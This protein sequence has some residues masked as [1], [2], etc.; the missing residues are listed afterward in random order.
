MASD[1]HLLVIASHCESEGPLTGLHVVARTFAEALRHQKRGD[2]DVDGN[3][4]RAGILL[5]AD[6]KTTEEAVKLAAVSARDKVLVLVWIGHGRAHGERFFLMPFE[7]R[8]E[9]IEASGI[10]LIPLLDLIRQQE[11]GGLLLTIDACQSGS[12][13]ADA[14]KA[15]VETLGPTAPIVILTATGEAAAYDLSFTKGL[16]ELLR[17]G[18]GNADRELSCAMLRDRLCELARKQTAHLLHYHGAAPPTQLW[19]SHNIAY[20]RRAHSRAPELREQNLMLSQVIA[21]VA[22][23]LMIDSS[24]IA[25]IADAGMGKTTLSAMLVQ[26]PDNLRAM[27]GRQHMLAASY[28][29]SQDTTFFRIVQSLSDQFKLYDSFKDATLPFEQRKDLSDD[30]RLLLEPLRTWVPTLD[31]PSSAVKITVLIDSLDSIGVARPRVIA[32]LESLGSIPGVRVVFTSRSGVEVPDKFEKVELGRLADAE[33]KSYLAGMHVDP[34]VHDALLTR[35]EGNWLC[36]AIFAEEAR[37]RRISDPAQITDLTLEKAFD[38]RLE[39]LEIGVEPAGGPA[40]LLTVLFVTLAAAGTGAAMPV[41]LLRAAC[42]I[43]SGPSTDTEFQAALKKLGGLTSYGYSNETT[44]WGLFH[45]ELVSHVHRAEKFRA[46]VLVAHAAIVDTLQARIPNRKDAPSVEWRYAFD[47][48]LDHWLASGRLVGARQLVGA[49]RRFKSIEAMDPRDN[50]SFWSRVSRLFTENLEPDHPVVLTARSNFAAWVGYAG[51]ARGARDLFGNLLPEHQRALGP[52][53]SD[54]LTT[55]ANLA[56]WTG[57]AGDAA[58]ARDLFAD[59]LPRHTRILGANDPHVLL[60][61]SNLAR[62]TGEAGDIHGAR[63]LLTILLPEYEEVLGADDAAVLMTRHNLAD[64]VGKCGDIE[65]ARDLFAA[66]LPDHERV[67]GAD[68]PEVLTTRG[69]LAQCT[70]EAGDIHAAR[71]LLVAY[72]TDAERALGPDHRNVLN[73]RANLAG[74]MRRSGDAQGAREIFAALLPKY[75]QILGP[76]HPDV[77]M[78]RANHAVCMGEA[79]DA[80]GARALLAA[81]LADRERVIGRDHPDVLTMRCNLAGFTGECGDIAAALELYAVVLQEQE[82]VLGV[83]H[84]DALTTRAQTA[85]WMKKSG[86]VREARDLF[87]ALLPDMKRV[88]GADHQDVLVTRANHALCTGEAGDAHGARNLFAALLPDRERVLGV[89]HSDTLATRVSLALW[90]GKCDDVCGA[91]DLYAALLSDYE[92]TLASDHPDVLEARSDLASWT[93]K[94]G[95]AARARDLFAALLADQER[96]LGADHP[97]VLATRHN[98]AEWTGQAGDA[99]GAR[100]LFTALALDRER[101]FGAESHLVLATRA[102]VAS[103]TGRAGDA[104]GARDLYAAL[105]PI[106]ERVLGPDDPNVLNSRGNH[107]SWTGRAGDVGAAHDL[108]AA[109][110]LDQERVLGLGHPDVLS[111][112]KNLTNCVDD[113][114]ETLTSQD[115]DRVRRNP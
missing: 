67:L 2:C 97:E 98:L 82:R 12:A 62:W 52:D 15:W 70:G 113:I 13:L 46:R 90:T 66:L 17:D 20:D 83:N 37:A 28:F 61:R 1:R 111:T 43:Q 68:H 78:M 103:W 9:T 16:T 53:N 7:A 27:T 44:L 3:G 31:E 42:K 100:N 93:G 49:L 58:G 56:F 14:L 35:I 10:E 8:K 64:L 24:N 91:R 26:M 30:E 25:L 107:A 84:P 101:I 112:R 48:E 108:Y 18:V 34:A 21:S 6:R 69:A 39:R 71:D 23:R 57:E 115:A 81:L 77:L 79:G 106:C 99:D 36:A 92:L 22:R 96:A 74:W 104:S 87:A 33:A 38:D 105:V 76:E 63:D 72:L 95:G 60:A 59:F 89:T 5:D 41:D 80:R 85:S 54:V 102:N 11:P 29:A 75:T 88:L 40:G 50:R 47:R 110:L 109:L 51:D 86:D 4:G 65:K 19:M 55:E 114:N 94:A 32:L 45:Q 73:A